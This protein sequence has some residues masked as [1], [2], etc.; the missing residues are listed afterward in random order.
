MGTI[1]CVNPYFLSCK[2][3]FN[4]N[5]SPILWDSMPIGLTTFSYLPWLSQLLSLRLLSPL[6]LVHFSTHFLFSSL[7][8]LGETLILVLFSPSPTLAYT[9]PVKGR[10]RNALHSGPQTTPSP[11]S[12]CIAHCVSHI[13]SL[14]CSLISPCI[15]SLFLSFPLR[16]ISCFLSH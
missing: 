9:P 15:L 5:I 13:H 11:P 6:Q 12:C 1:S 14:C 7:H 4:F 2:F 10:W 8:S 16:K 3:F